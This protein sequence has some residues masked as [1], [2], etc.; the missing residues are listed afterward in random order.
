M[1]FRRRKLLEVCALLPTQERRVLY[2]MVKSWFS[3]LF[4][5]K[6]HEGSLPNKQALAM[7]ELQNCK[8]VLSKVIALIAELLSQMW[9]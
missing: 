7:T 4:L 9:L 6:R 8:A 5:L 3:L 2:N 1:N